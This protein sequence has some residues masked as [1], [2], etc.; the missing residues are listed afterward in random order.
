MLFS[1]WKRDLGIRRKKEHRRNQRQPWEAQ[2]E[3]EQRDCIQPLL[4]WGFDLP[5]EQTSLTKRCQGGWRRGLRVVLSVV[6]PASIFSW[7]ESPVWRLGVSQYLTSA[8]RTAGHLSIWGKENPP[9]P[10]ELPC[11]YETKE[12]KLQM[13]GKFKTWSN[14]LIWLAGT[15]PLIRPNVLCLS[16]LQPRDFSFFQKGCFFAQ[17]TGCG[18]WTRCSCILLLVQLARGGSRSSYPMIWSNMAHLVWS[19]S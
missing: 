17:I 14:N 5:W 19:V 9:T 13:T 10:I 16:L 3:L 8:L 4:P 6:L 15:L 7:E 12:T 1:W 18:F 2:M 11:C